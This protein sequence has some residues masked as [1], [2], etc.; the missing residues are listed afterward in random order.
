MSRP[1]AVVAS[2]DWYCQD[3][4]WL[5]ILEHKTWMIMICR[6]RLSARFLFLFE[7]WMHIIII[8]DQQQ[9]QTGN[10]AGKLIGE[11]QQLIN[12]AN[13]S[14]RSLE[15]MR[16]INIRRDFL[17]SRNS[18]WLLLLLMSG[19]FFFESNRL[20]SLPLFVERTDTQTTT[21]TQLCPCEQQALQQQ[22]PATIGSECSR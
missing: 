21:G 20:V 12:G 4:R 22:V 5:V 6:H 15:L 11:L 10:E 14:I 17:I 9:P 18:H 13:R 16:E 3:T 19:I 1:R 7:L 2:A 8:G